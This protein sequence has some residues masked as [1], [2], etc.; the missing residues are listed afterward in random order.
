[1]SELTDEGRGKAAQLAE[2]HGVSREA[3]EALLRA[4]A[5][6]GGMQA[7]FHH[8][9]LGGMG[10][11]SRGGM[12]MIGDMF[13][14]D[15]KARVA[16]LCDD[17]AGMVQAGGVARASGVQATG[18]TWWPRGLGQPAA[19]G[20]QN[21]VRY[22][23]FPADRR[24]VIDRGGRISVHDTGD[25]RIGGVSQSQGAG[26]TLSF[27]SQHGTLTLADLPEVDG[28]DPL[29]RPAPGAAAA[30]PGP[31]SP[32]APPPDAP[33]P[34][35]PQPRGGAE[36]APATPAAPPPAEAGA[37]DDILDKIERLGGLAERG[38]ITTAEFEAKKAELL[39]RL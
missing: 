28:G 26:D 19:V 2:A 22:A 3:A 29:G 27:A 7:Q 13:N 39:A 1:M 6:G 36:P 9:D 33:P 30:D 21:A 4:M 34:G 38:I 12:L 10:Q 14:H 17:A 11:W 23:I 31:R 20:A 37:E 16:R 5:D 32:D 18:D 35:G 25:H 24:L 15:L 8:P